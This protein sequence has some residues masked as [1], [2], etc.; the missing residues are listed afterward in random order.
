[1]P[2]ESQANVTS[3]NEIRNTTILRKKISVML[4]ENQIGYEFFKS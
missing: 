4:Y 1:M 3:S 2:T